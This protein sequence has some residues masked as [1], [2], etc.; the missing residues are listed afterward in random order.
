MWKNFTRRRSKSLAEALVKCQFSPEKY[1]ELYNDLQHMAG[2]ADEIARHYLAFGINEGRI[3]QFEATLPD[4]LERLKTKN[5]SPLDSKTILSSYAQGCMLKEFG[6]LKFHEQGTTEPYADFSHMTGS[7]E[8][9]RFGIHHQH[10]VGDSHSAAYAHASYP[11]KHGLWMSWLLCTGG[12]ARGLVNDHSKLGYRRAIFA[13]LDKI[14]ATDNAS[15]RV[16]FCFGQVDV[17]FVYYNRWLS[18]DLP[19]SS[20]KFIDCYAFIQDTVRLYVSFLREVAAKGFAVSA[21]GILPPCI[22]TPYLKRLLMAYAQLRPLHDL[23]R[24]P[25]MKNIG[26]ANIPDL[27]TRTFIHHLFNEELAREARKHSIGFH[28]VFEQLLGE[29]GVVKLEHLSAHGL[30]DHHLG[31]PSFQPQCADMLRALALEANSA[32][33]ALLPPELGETAE[34]PAS[35]IATPH[36]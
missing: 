4:L 2:D 33:A 19:H 26:L 22:E 30:A 25:L 23:A 7:C 31:C 29:D 35:R 36:M 24:G 17:E 27:R 5:V 13:H 32:P 12:S 11:I 6:Y 8:L 18:G 14:A 10:I 9:D 1:T 20:F 28:S 21:V 3:L 15:R 16:L 34:E